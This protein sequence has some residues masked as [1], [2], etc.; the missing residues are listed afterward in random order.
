MYKQAAK[1]ISA[2][3]HPLLIPVYIMTVLLFMNTIYSYYPMSVKLYLIWVMVLYAIVLPALTVML[4]KRIQRIRGVRL[5]RHH[6]LSIIMLVGACCFLLCALTLMKSPSLTIF[7]KVAVAAMLCELFCL[8]MIQFTRI[9]LHLTAMGAGVA[10]LVIL[11]IIGEN[12]LFWVMLISI[13]SAGILAS[14][15]LYMGR[16]RSLQLL[17]S[18]V[19]GFLICIV[20]MLYI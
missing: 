15:R 16:H 5:P 6:F 19:G 2:I 10:A 18:F 17:T 11:N 20:T 9:S 3:F 12:S 1:I 8:G 4:V 7:R 13:I 14:A